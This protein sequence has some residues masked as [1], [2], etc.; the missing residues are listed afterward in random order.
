MIFCDQILFFYPSSILSQALF[1]VRQPLSPLFFLS[2]SLVGHRLVIGSRPLPVVAGIL[3]AKFIVIDAHL[4]RWPAGAGASGAGHPHRIEYYPLFCPLFYTS[5]YTLF[6]NWSV[7]GHIM[8]SDHLQTH[9]CTPPTPSYQA[10]ICIHLDS[11]SWHVLQ[12]RYLKPSSKPISL[13]K[14]NFSF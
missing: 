6:L 8:L 14:K 13:N 5:F 1:S 7:P 4:L 2:E 12:T 3:S 11:G 10:Y 9:R